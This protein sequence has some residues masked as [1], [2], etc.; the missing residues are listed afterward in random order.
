MTATDPQ[1]TP[2]RLDHC[3]SDQPDS[4]VKAMRH[5]NLFVEGSKGTQPVEVEESSDG[6]FCVLH[7]PGFVEGIAAGDTIKV[8]DWERGLFE[9]VK[10]GGNV[11]IKWSTPEKIEDYLQDAISI[12]EEIDARF[13]GAIDHAAVWTVP[14][15]AGFPTIE[16]R[17][18]QVSGLCDGSTWWYG[19]VYDENDS[20]LNW[21]LTD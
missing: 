17:M 13:D 19:N 18:A 6:T 11:A 5:I 21:W 16:E 8:S 2:V 10:R 9:V 20:P 7:S 15:E 1:R 3:A 14:V 4:T 12:L